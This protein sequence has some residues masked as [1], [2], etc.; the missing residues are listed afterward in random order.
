MGIH[1]PFSRPMFT[2][3]G[4]VLTS[5]GSKNLAKGQFTIVNTKEADV[6][7]AKVVSNFNALQK[8]AVLEMRLGTHK[9]AG[10]RTNNVPIRYSSETFKLSDVVDVKA[11][12]PQYFK[13]TY[14]DYIV[15]F[16]GINATSA[17]TMDDN[18]TTLLNVTVKGDHVGFIT[19]NCEYTFT[20]HFGK[21]VGE[22]DQEVIKRAAEVL[23]KQL[24]HK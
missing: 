19:G 23:K 3:Q 17:I 14:D 21:E 20:V 24:F 4:S 22:T 2:L 8:D 11:T 15:G 13:R 10:V 9:V 5:G 1:R 7:G 12:T 18:Q 16:D 6:N